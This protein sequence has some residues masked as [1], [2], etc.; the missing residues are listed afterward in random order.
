MNTAIT[1]DFVS[2]FKPN[3]LSTGRKQLTAWF[4]YRNIDDVLSINNPNFENLL[5]QM[6]LVELK[7]KVT[8]ESI[9]SASYLDLLPSIRRDD[10]LHTSIYNKHD[11]FD[12]HITNFRYFVAIYQF[13]P[14]IVSLSRSLYDI[15]GLAPRMHVL[16]KGGTAFKKDSR[17]GIRHGMLEIVSEEVLWSIR[18]DNTITKFLSQEC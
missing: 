16:F 12:F 11:H 17:T 13:C 1:V 18:Y 9:T 14:P 8:T 4:T 7:M 2:L 15:P 5:G 3:L 6:Y 10:Q